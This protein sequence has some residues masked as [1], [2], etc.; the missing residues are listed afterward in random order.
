MLRYTQS[1]M[2]QI[3]QTAVCNR[4]HTVDQQLCRWLL[5]NHDLLPGN[6]LVMTHELIANMLG[7]RREGVSVAAARLQADRIIKYF[8]GTITILNRDKLEAAA[9]ECYRVVVDEYDRLL[10]P[11]V[12]VNR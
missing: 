10:G 8:R 4:L 12:P 6:E 3:S 7:V 5:M 2:C 1:L 11:Y 9:C